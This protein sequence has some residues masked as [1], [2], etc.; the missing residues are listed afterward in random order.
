MLVCLHLYSSCSPC[1]CSVFHICDSLV[2][3]AGDNKEELQTS[4]CS[5]A[6]DEQPAPLEGSILSSSDRDD[7]DQFRQSTPVPQSEEGPDPFEGENSGLE[8]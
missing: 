6:H 4:P 7:G 5:P 2:S 1:S 8:K 3:D